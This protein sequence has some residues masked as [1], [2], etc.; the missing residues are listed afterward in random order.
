MRATLPITALLLG[1]GCDRQ[2]TMGEART[3]DASG[4][5][6]PP[7]PRVPMPEGV[8]VIDQA[9]VLSGAEKGRIEQRSA[10]VSQ[11]IGRKL[12]VVL[13]R[14]SHGDT[15]ERVTWAI[16]PGQGADRP[17]MLVVDVGS[18][19]IRVDGATDAAAA[20]AIAAAVRD[21]VKAGRF[22]LGISR[23]LDQIAQ[24]E[25]QSS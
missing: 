11:A 25:R 16:S 6:V 12:T 15:L 21:E 10:A 3:F 5:E 23:G 14:P 24:V 22:A 17:L 19:A 18:A 7:L 13:L 2:P 8:A 1:A 4:N 9:G 20:A